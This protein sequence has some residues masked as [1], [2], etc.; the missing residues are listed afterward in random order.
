GESGDVARHRL[1]PLDLRPCLAA[2]GAGRR[3]AG[4]A[5]ASS[6]SPD[7]TNGPPKALGLIDT[8][9]GRDHVSRLPAG[10][11]HLP[12]GGGADRPAGTGGVPAPGLWRRRSPAAPCGGTAAPTRP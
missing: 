9:A 3:R 12:G 8:W 5:A 4:L 2:P 1:P 6:S 11:G 7:E 10:Q